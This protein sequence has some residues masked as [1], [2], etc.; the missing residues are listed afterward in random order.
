M[1][2][3]LSMTF[4]NDGVG[5]K[6]YGSTDLSRFAKPSEMELAADG[7]I[8]FTFTNEF[9]VNRILQSGNRTIVFWGDGTKTIVKRADDEEDNPYVAFT[10]ALAIKTY[11]SNS[12]LKSI[13]DHKLEVQERINGKMQIVSDY[14]FR[15]NIHKFF[16]SELRSFLKETG[17][18]DE[19]ES[20]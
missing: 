14:E 8:H 18:K 1:G 12:K 3:E 6:A 10:A 15:K 16:K 5:F 20:N 2:K 13:I 19:K 17:K 9:E 11:G 7:T 4:C